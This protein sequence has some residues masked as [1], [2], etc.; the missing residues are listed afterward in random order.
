MNSCISDMPASRD[1]SAV[2]EQ[3]RSCTENM[4]FNREAR[5][6][7]HNL[8]EALAVVA[9]LTSTTLVVVPAGH[10]RLTPL[11]ASNG[12]RTAH[13]ALANLMLALVAL[14]Q[15]ARAPVERRPGATL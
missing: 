6:L 7:G 8:L 9:L 2:R 4:I 12:S 11:G 15:C 3:T 13:E 5:Y 1:S 14:H 10:K